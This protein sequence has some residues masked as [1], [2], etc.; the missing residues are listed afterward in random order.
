MLQIDL[1]GK[2]ALVTGASGELGRTISRTLAGCGADVALHYNHGAERAEAVA[3]ELREMGRRAVTVQADVTDAQSVMQMQQTVKASLGVPTLIVANAVIQYPWTS[4]L[5]Q[6]LE[7]FQSQFDSCAMQTV[8]LA[9]AFLPDMIAAGAGRYVAINT[10][11]A[12]MAESGVGAYTAGKRAL[13]GIIRVLAK[14]V[15]CHN[16]TVNQVAPGWTISE[17]DRMN[18][19]ESAP[20]YDKTVPLG[21]RGTDAEIA[22]MV[23]F[24]LSDLA[25]F[26]TGAYIPVSGGRVMPAI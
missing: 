6:P 15:G 25:S 18:H 20:D 21:R 10:E 8:H 9:K 22:Q 12:A 3:N 11:C 19:T 7:D 1:T 17:R 4:I 24:L 2:I 13:D 16:I 14:E 26:T 23:A 5:E